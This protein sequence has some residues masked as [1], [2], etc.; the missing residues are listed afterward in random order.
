L[1]KFTSRGTDTFEKVGWEEMY[2]Y[3][4]RAVVAIARTY[5]GADGERRLKSDGYEPEMIDACHHA[6]TRTMKLRGGMGLLGVLGK[7]GL[8]RWSNMLALLDQT[9]HKVEPK[10]ALGGR[11]W[12][13]YTWHG[14]QAPGHPF[15]HGLQA[16]DCDLNDMHHA[17]LHIQC[18]KNLVENKMAD[19]H[20]F[21][22]MMERGGRIV[23]ITPE[24]SPAS[25]KAN[26]WIQVRPGC[27]DTALFLGVTKVMMDR[28]WYDEKFVKAFTD[29]PLLI[30]T[31][32][33][34]RL[35]AADVFPNYQ[36]GLKKGS[37]PTSIAPLGRI[38]T[39]ATSNCGQ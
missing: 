36:P 14:D 39:L 35:R 7:Y 12:S 21:I 23:V 10:E 9:I 28:G 27:T 30:R 8:Y 3:H 25:T 18:G 20:W 5:S 31:D 29:F 17:K 1:Y 32:T 34:K 2:R 15:V 38:A 22:E 13:N 4:A 11:I 6:G 26:Y 19:A 24:Y 37:C 33:L 16:S